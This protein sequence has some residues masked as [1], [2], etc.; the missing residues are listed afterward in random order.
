MTQP[1]L[2][3]VR[4]HDTLSELIAAREGFE[5]RPF[6]PSHVE[7]VI[8]GGYYLGAHM[9]GGVAIREPGYDKSW[10]QSDVLV[11]LPATPEQAA[12]FDAYV[13]AKIG[14]PYDWKAV[15]GFLVPGDLHGP[16][17][18]ICSAMMTGAARLTGALPF[19]LCVPYHAVSPLMLMAMV[20]AVVPIPGAIDFEA[21]RPS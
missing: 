11:D 16:G 1:R 19:P 3:F 10:L 14:A 6:T 20:G 21:R 5:A 15:L 8:A 12:A 17:D 7:C 13:R 4:G 9:D 2:R 18:Y